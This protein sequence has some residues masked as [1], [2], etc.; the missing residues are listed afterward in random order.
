MG[1]RCLSRVARDPQSADLLPG[2]EILSYFD[3]YAFQMKVPREGAVGVR[4][5]NLVP[6]ISAG[7]W[8]AY[9]MYSTAPR[10]YYRITDV[11]SIVH[12]TVRSRGTVRIGS[13]LALCTEPAVGLSY[14]CPFMWPHPF[15]KGLRL[16]VVQRLAERPIVPFDG[17]SWVGPAHVPTT[18]IRPSPPKY[19]RRTGRQSDELL[20][21]NQ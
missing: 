17:T 14:D 9:V 1:V 10:R 11:R 21:A 4:N 18:N 6:G 8:V 19:C 16:L 2:R 12:S 7:R 3:L 5:D 15:R 13:I 20:T